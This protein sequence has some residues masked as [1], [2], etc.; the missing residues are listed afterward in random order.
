[1]TLPEGDQLIT[2]TH[3]RG[4][5]YTVFVTLMKTGDLRYFLVNDADEYVAT[6][7]EGEVTTL[8]TVTGSL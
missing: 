1:M 3:V 6:L 4:S 2:T 5:H 8:L 7:S